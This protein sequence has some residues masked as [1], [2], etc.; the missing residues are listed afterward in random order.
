MSMP[1]TFSYLFAIHRLTHLRAAILTIFRCTV[2]TV[3]RVIAQRPM[4]ITSPS[5]YMAQLK[6]ISKQ[7]KFGIQILL[8]V[9]NQIKLNCNLFAVSP[10][11]QRKTEGFGNKTASFFIQ[12]WPLDQSRICSRTYC[13]CVFTFEGFRF[14]WLFSFVYFLDNLVIKLSFAATMLSLSSLCIWRCPLELCLRSSSLTAILTLFILIF[15]VCLGNFC[16]DVAQHLTTTR[17][18]LPTPGFGSSFSNVIENVF[19][20]IRLDCAFMIWTVFVRILFIAFPFLLDQQLA[21][22]K[23]LLNLLKLVQTLFH[24]ASLRFLS[25][26]RFPI[27]CLL[28]FHFANAFFSFH[29]RVLVWFL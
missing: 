10:F 26:I 19:E 22:W 12:F 13:V 1:S 25:K 17:A 6:W 27:E 28:H 15:F 3:H 20:R 9:E 21:N 29:I 2:Y 4:H 5:Q 11:N 14:G 23:N 18:V 8:S 16:K 7:L 24:W